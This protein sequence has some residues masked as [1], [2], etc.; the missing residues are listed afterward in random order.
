MSHA[1]LPTGTK[2]IEEGVAAFRLVMPRR[3]LGNYR[4]FGLVPLFPGL[5]IVGFSG[6]WLAN[7]WPAFDKEHGATLAFSL[8]FSLFSLPGLVGGTGLIILGLAIMSN[9]TRS[10]LVFNPQVIKHIQRFAF[11]RWS[12]KLPSGTLAAISVDRNSKPDSANDFGAINFAMEEAS[13]MMFAPGYSM[14]ILTPVAEAL[15]ALIAQSKVAPGFDAKVYNSDRGETWDPYPD[16]TEPDSDVPIDAEA[17][18]QAESVDRVSSARHAPA[19]AAPRPDTTDITVMQHPQGLAIAIPPIGLKTGPKVLLG[20]GALFSGIPLTI[21]ITLAITHPP[22]FIIP[23]LFLSL[24][25]AVG[26]LLFTIGLNEARKKTLLAVSPDTLAIRTIGI[27]KP[28]EQIVPRADLA[29]IHI[30]PSGTS[31]NNVPLP[32]LKI[33]LTGDRDAI[34]MLTERTE[35]E[36][37]WVAGLLQQALKVGAEKELEPDTRPDSAIAR[38]A[39]SKITLTPRDGG[40]AIEVPPAGLSTGGLIFSVFWLG[41]SATM[42]GVVIKSHEGI[43]IVLFLSLFVAIGVAALAYTIKEGRQRYLLA[44]TRDRL[45]YQR[46]SPFGTVRHQFDRSEITGIG[47]GPSGTSVNGKPVLEMHV[48][49]RNRGDIGLLAGHSTDD[50]VWISAKLRET[51]GVKKHNRG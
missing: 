42:M 4:W 13:G 21:V 3:I 10:E 32:E 36:I 51:L 48:G 47:V 18:L 40:W 35:S 7:T 41:T 31:V 1:N 33:E 24:F 37:N 23:I 22:R 8:V 16:D 49:I 14:S 39:N 17:P 27:F 46:I 11:C 29:A 28:R 12:W 26:L 5:A 15:S 34:G 50:L 9:W 25:I 44:V 30:G 2:L 45:A 20:A 19:Q 38:P 6:N 43:G